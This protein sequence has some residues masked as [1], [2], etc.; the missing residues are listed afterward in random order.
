MGQYWDFLSVTLQRA[1]LRNGGAKWIEFFFCEQ[2]FLVGSLTVPYPSDKVDTWLEGFTGTAPS[3]HDE[4]VLRFP[5]E[6]LLNIV[7][8]VPNIRDRVCLALTCKRLL[9]LSRDS[10][11]ELKKR[12][13]APWVGGRLICIGDYTDASDLP[14]GFFTKAEKRRLRWD[15]KDNMYGGLSYM[16]DKQTR[17]FLG[18]MTLA[19]SSLGDMVL[20]PNK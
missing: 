17:L 4:G 2:P 3:A 19:R 6:I 1:G 13:A 14:E 18:T 10:V 12:L 7:E 11:E 16:R 8:L 20:T 9:S 15:P 5:N